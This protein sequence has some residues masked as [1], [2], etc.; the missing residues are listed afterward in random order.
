MDVKRGVIRES[1]RRWVLA[2]PLFIPLVAVCGALW[3][4]QLWGLSFVACLLAVVCKQWRVC[5]AAVLCAAVAW[6]HVLQ[7]EAE[8]ETLLN[9]IHSVA[10]PR[11]C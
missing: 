8:Q 1:V 11:V 2:S 10:A 5:I 3:G 4:G 9:K 6:L 7:T